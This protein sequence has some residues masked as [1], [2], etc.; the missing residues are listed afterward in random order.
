MA[1]I[2]TEPN[3]RLRLTVRPGAANLFNVLFQSGFKVRA[4]LG[5]S[6][7]TFLSERLGLDK[8]YVQNR[9]QTV[10]MNNKAVDDPATATITEGAGLALSAA[11]PGLV[12]ATLRKGGY[13]AAMREGISH[14][15]ETTKASGGDAWVR[16]KLFNL[17]AKDL[18]AALLERGIYVESGSLEDF[19]K[20]QSPEFW[21]GCRQIELDGQ[22]LDVEDLQRIAWKEIDDPV[23]LEVHQAG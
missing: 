21:A 2:T 8:E 4:G 7:E 15:A 3:T 18:G 22:P 9:I 5:T 17:V 13:Y 14:G 11:L 6:I 23:F 16:V 12:G 10:F 1:S 19:F 20:N